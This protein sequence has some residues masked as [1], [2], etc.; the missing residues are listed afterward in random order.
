MYHVR[1]A[2]AVSQWRSGKLMML[3][4]VVWRE[5]STR[6]PEMPFWGQDVGSS[7]GEARRE[8]DGGV[9]PSAPEDMC[10]TP[11]YLYGF[12]ISRAIPVLINTSKSASQRWA[13]D[14]CVDI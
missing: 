1:A 12:L 13:G 4:P 5:F 8:G 2:W 14:T 11:S 7:W 9:C 3:W 6:G 10:L